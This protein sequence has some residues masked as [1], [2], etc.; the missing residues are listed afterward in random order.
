[1]GH[2]H[3]LLCWEQHPAYLP[4][5]RGCAGTAGTGLDLSPTHMGTRFLASTAVGVAALPHPGRLALVQVSPGDAA[6]GTEQPGIAGQTP[7]PSTT[8]E[9]ELWFRWLGLGLH[10]R[11]W[12]AW[13]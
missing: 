9:A 12:L 1:M 3:T 10:S 2:L 4:R 6:A 8:L 11:A 13:H 5:L 7:G